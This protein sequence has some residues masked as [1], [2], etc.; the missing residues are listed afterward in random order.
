MDRIEQLMKEAKPRI[1]DPKASQGVDAA[2]SAVFSTDPNVV[3]LAGRKPA[4]RTAVRAAAATIL[5]AAAV[6]GALV[7]GGNLGQQPVPAPA[8]TGT[9]TVTAAPTPTS[10]AAPT[11]TGSAPA[12][13]SSNGVECTV[14]NID[15]QR[16]DQEHAIKPI[17]ADEQRYYTVLGCA[18]GWLAY[19]ISD[20]GV[21]AL[22]LDG[23]NAWFLIAKLENGRFLTDFKQQWSSV[24]NWK[25]Q[26]L[27]NDV[28][29]NG[30]QVTPQQA[31]DKEFTDKGIPVDLRPQLVGDGPTSADTGGT[32]FQQASQGHVVTFEHPAA[33]AVRPGT[34]APTDGSLALVVADG[35]GTRVASLGFGA[36][37]AADFDISCGPQGGFEIL[38]SVPLQGISDPSARM[39]YGVFK[40]EQLHGALLVAHVEAAGEQTCALSPVRVDG[41]ALNFDT[42]LAQPSEAGAIDLRFDSLDVARGW[43]AS[44][45]YHQIATVLATLRITPGQS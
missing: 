43:A 3:T 14:A 7:V 6:A 2:R 12:T 23:G 16:N 31:M 45:E 15:Q 18:D 25:F 9:P 19:A 26:T 39:V 28:A 35:F 36:P 29:Q 37:A 22:Q 32:T 44:P 40:G 5:A 21:R 30:Q 17:P 8:Q 1:G 4:R 11:A 38:E 27:N 34:A 41:L 10:S 24:F 13:L 42:G 20:D 33:F